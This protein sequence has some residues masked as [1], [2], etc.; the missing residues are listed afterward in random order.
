MS[1]LEPIHDGEGL[2]AAW[3]RFRLDMRR[4]FARHPESRG[5]YGWSDLLGGHAL[6]NLVVEFTRERP[7][8][9]AKAWLLQCLA[10]AV[11][12]GLVAWTGSAR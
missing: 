12:L 8:T 2:D 11:L 5:R 4:P 1:S 6:I 7:H 10:I 3:R 9:F